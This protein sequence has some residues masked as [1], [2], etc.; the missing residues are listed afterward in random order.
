MQARSEAVRVG[1]HTAQVNPS[2]LPTAEARPR[3][4]LIKLEE[5]IAPG[6]GIIAPTGNTNGIYTPSG[7]K[8]CTTPQP[9]HL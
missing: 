8:I 4:K 2:S 6:G 5:R 7:L 1:N 9:T 3:F